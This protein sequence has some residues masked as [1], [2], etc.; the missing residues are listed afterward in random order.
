[1]ILSIIRVSVYTEGGKL[2][3]FQFLVSVY[4]EEGNE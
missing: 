1:M 3:V 4:K 2:M